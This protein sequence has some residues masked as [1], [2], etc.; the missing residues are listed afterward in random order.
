MSASQASAT[1]SFIGGGN[2]ASALIGGL[3]Q[4][5]I[6][7]DHITAADPNPAA[8]EQLSSEYGVKVDT[9]N[10][11]AI[12]D[13]DII[14]LAVKPQIMPLV[15]DEIGSSVGTDQ[16]VVSIAA[17]IT[18]QCITQAMNPEQA[19]IRAMPNTPALIG[20]GITGMFANSSCRNDQKEMAAHIL[21]AAGETVWVEDEGLIDVVTAVSGSGPAYFFYMV[22]ALREAG[23]HYG[24]QPEAAAKLALHTAQGAGVMAAKSELDVA[25]LRRRVT[26]PGG[27][28]QAA[29][30]SL[31]SDNFKDIVDRAVQAATDR[32]KALAAMADS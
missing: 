5:G 27:T 12:H 6:P 23:E 26:S 7:A 8:G 29:L 3:I 17:G 24:L 1:I 15:L 2:M 13:A 22:E 4:S 11:R 20:L 32:G 21:S 25:E 10:Q 9:D 19:I 30:E 14:V 31:A 16:L 18:I 28:T